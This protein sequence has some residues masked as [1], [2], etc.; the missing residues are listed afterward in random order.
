MDETDIRTEPA[1][2][3]CSS[4]AHETATVVDVHFRN[5]AKIYYFDP[6]TLALKAGDHVIIDTARGDEYG[7]CASGCH[8]VPMCQIV[9][10]LRKV[11]RL[12]NEHDERVNEEN[13]QKEKRAFEVC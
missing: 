11:L 1:A 2:G 5:N 8:E 12:A 4:C 6:D 13:Q 3:G 9:P 7:V 10:P